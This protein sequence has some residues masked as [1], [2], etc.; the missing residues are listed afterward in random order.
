MPYFLFYIGSKYDRIFKVNI[1]DIKKELIILAKQL[2]IN[3][4]ED[5]IE[6]YDNKDSFYNWCLSNNQN[7]ITEW[8]S[9]LNQISIENYNLG[10]S[11]KVWWRCKKDSRHI[12]DDTISHRK[13]GRGCPICSNKRILVGVN[14]LATTHPHLAFEW[15][16]SNDL[17]PTEVTYGSTTMIKWICPKGHHY[18]AIV[19]SRANGTGC[20]ICAGK[21]VLKGY[22]DLATTHPEF[23]KD[24][25]YDKNG[26]LTPDKITYGST[27][28]VWWKCDK[29][30]EW[31]ISPNNRTNQDSGCPYCTNKKVLVGYNDLVTVNPRLASEWHP[32]KNGTLTPRD[33]TYGYNKKVWW[34]C[35]TCGYEWETDVAHRVKDDS[36]CAVCAGKVML[37]GYNDFAT[38]HPELLEEWDYEKNTIDPSDIPSSYKKKVWW[39]CPN[40]HSYETSVTSRALQNTGC[41]YC[42][43]EKVLP[44]YNDL[45]TLNPELAK[46]FD[47]EKNTI[48]IKTL[49]PYSNK[50]V[51]WLCKEYKH[52][53]MAPVNDRSSGK[54]CPYCSNPPRKILKGFNDLFTTNPELKDSWDYEKNTINPETISKGSK[55][56]A[57]WICDRG[58]SWQADVSSRACNHNGCKYCASGLQSS[59]P[60]KIMGFYLKQYFDDIVENVK[61]DFMEG[62]ELDIYIPSIKLAIEYDGANWHKNIEKD[63]KKDQLCNENDIKLIRVREEGC[64][65]YE[66][67]SIKIIANKPNNTMKHMKCVIDELLK[68]INS[69]YGL[70]ITLDVNIDR[71]YNTIIKSIEYLET[72]DSIAEFY[73]IS[74]KEWD[75]S[76]NGKLSPYSFKPNSNI[77]VWWKCSKCGYEWESIIES[78]FGKGRTQGCPCCS[79]KIVISGQNDLATLYPEVLKYWDYIKNEK[80][81]EEIFPNSNKS[82]WWTCEKGHSYEMRACS[83]TSNKQGC[84]ICSNHK[85]LEGYNDLATTCPEIAKEWNYDKNGELKP[86]MVMK[87]SERKVWWKCSKCGYEWETLIYSRTGPNDT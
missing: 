7:L 41:P 18:E 5:S 50:K 79:G 53:W 68:T 77:K 76:K 15:D 80:R 37:K 36:G 75:Y 33:V 35:K 26:D 56:K 85:L 57:Y 49:M 10:N 64:P 3:F 30:H 51:W 46:E 86:T 19:S 38:L 48:D 22:N 11:K 42:T 67:A 60:E 63:K 40:G 84:P 1:N 44:G 39:N 52:S 12:W 59:I 23:A 31:F 66:S 65:S 83:K 8:A 21:S 29:G 20:S 43:N 87:G 2:S 16:T 58:H 55:Y 6:E 71:D 73:P 13:A 54:G 70:T 78:R 74:L 14:D 45:L 62:Y 61:L 24:W 17:K 81:P 32:T 47:Y 82:Y 28:K 69:F 25:D 27:K 34:K 4:D 72:K 9:D